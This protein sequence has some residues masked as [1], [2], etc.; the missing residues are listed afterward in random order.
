MARTS[1]PTGTVTFLFTDIEGS[2]RLW[3]QDAAGMEVA[4]ANHDAILRRAIETHA[5]HIFKTIGDAFCTAFS[6]PS[7]ALS[8]LR[9]LGRAARCA[10][11]WRS[12]RVSPSTATGTTSVAI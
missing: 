11:G 9:P 10:F 6:T 2:T 5:G 7:D 12:I 4:L 1:P 3:E 8:N